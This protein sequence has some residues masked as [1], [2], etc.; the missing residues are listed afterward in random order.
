ML[1][2]FASPAAPRSIEADLC[3]VGAGAAGIALALNFAGTHHSICLLEGGG[4]AHE[5]ESQALYE[6]SAV[7]VPWLCSLHDSRLRQFG[8]TTSREWG[9]GCTPLDALDFASRPWVPYSDWPIT[10]NELLPYYERARTIFQLGPEPFEDLALLAAT[11][12]QLV[13]NPL[14][15]D[16]ATLVNRYYLKSPLNFGEAQ[17]TAL[18][19]ARNVTALVHANVVDLEVNDAASAMT[20]VRVKSLT[21]RTGTVRARAFV[22]ACG[23]IE[24][25]RLLLAANKVESCGLGNRHDLVGRFFMDHPSGP[26]GTVVAS[27]PERFIDA[28]DHSYHWARQLPIYP[29]LYLSEAAQRRQE[30]L[31]ARCRLVTREAVEVPDGVAAFR[32]LLDR[33]RD[34]QLPP[35]LLLRQLR[36][37]GR[38]I[39]HVAVA[40]ARRLAGRDA[41]R[42]RLDLE[43]VFEQ[44]PNPASRITLS[45]DRDALGQRRARLDWRLTD[46]DWRSYRGLAHCFDAELRRRRIGYLQ[47]S[48][49]LRSERPEVNSMLGGVAHHLGTTRMSDDPRSGV[50]DSNCRVHGIANLFVSS[51]SVLPTGGVAG[52]TFTIVALGIRLADHLKRRLSLMPQPQPQAEALEAGDC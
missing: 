22:L 42:T 36:R 19:K 26:V 20:A 40:S 35:N 29:T 45:Y 4:F 47:I 10:R 39:G 46:L 25:A 21:G 49:W 6:G 33:A 31:N 13:P 41:V 43:G 34:R 11:I 18:E 50:V 38:D 51:G 14:G 8:G 32:E 48:D 15:F 37:I 44:A 28:Y 9:G 16:P 52:P 27:E 7:G 30:L 2:D 24:T 12:R 3:I 1:I 17:R 23:G 5:P